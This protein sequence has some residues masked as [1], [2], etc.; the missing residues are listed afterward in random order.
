MQH[1]CVS[2]VTILQGEFNCI[3]QKP[4]EERKPEKEETYSSYCFSV[5]LSYFLSFTLLPFPNA[6]VQMLKVNNKI[7]VCQDA[8]DLHSC[9]QIAK[10][11]FI[12]DHGHDFPFRN[13][14]DLITHPLAQKQSSHCQ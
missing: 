14:R 3:M 5:P 13:V 4:E 2:G 6:N 1:V 12:L 8:I 7:I 11:R 9:G 10:E